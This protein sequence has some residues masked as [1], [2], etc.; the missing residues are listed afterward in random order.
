MMFSCIGVRTPLAIVTA[1]QFFRHAACMQ[2]KVAA[3]APGILPLQNN[4]PRWPDTVKVFSP[5]DEIAYV[6]KEVNHVWAQNGG[7]HEH[8]QFSNH[9]FALLFKPGVYDVSVPVGYYTQVMGLG[10]N[11]S[12]VKFI[13]SKGVYSESASNDTRPGSLD[14]FWRSAENFET[15]ADHAWWDQS[16]GGMM[17]ATSQATPLRRIIVK[18]SL[19][20]FQYLPGNIL[21][22]YASGGFIANS[23]VNGQIQ[24][25]SQQQYFARNCEAGGTGDTQGWEGGVW[26][27]VFVGSKG[28]PSSNCGR[29]ET[30]P[31][32]VNV[33]L[34][35][36]AA[37]KPYIVME[38]DGKFSLVIPPVSTD[39][40]G[41]DHTALGARLVSFEQVYV[42][43]SARDTA[44]SINTMLR[45]GL[46]VVLSP[47]I[48]HLH[49]PL[50]L[51]HDNQV[52]LGLGLATLVAAN[53]YAAVKVG[54]V[55]GV[56]LA[57]VLLEAGDEAPDVLLEWGDA[58]HQGLAENP[59]VMHDIFTRVC[60]PDKPANPRVKAM[61]RINSGHVIGD[62]LWLWRADHTTHGF[63]KSGHCACDH[64]LQVNGDDV[65]M[66]GLAAEHA[67]KD[68]VQWKGERGRV[69]FFQAE[70]PYD[71]S[72]DYGEKG[73][74]GYRVDDSVRVHEAWG[75][76]IYHDFHDYSVV[77]KSGII[78]PRHLETSFVSPLSVFLGGKGKMHHVINDLGE[79]TSEAMSEGEA[80]PTWWCP[81]RHSSASFLKRR[82][83]R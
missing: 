57:G 12:D 16:P 26:N 75:I 59:G 11:P 70:L 2:A 39:R 5:D 4:P 47:G 83:L 17:W 45:A 77:V 41:I 56:R 27:N 6:Q 55:D 68:I 78:A 30:D 48:Y 13:S 53:R 69:Y 61:V 51:K 18:N 8:G 64:A 73:Y 52:L 21:A 67:L 49:E 14:T 46:H 60:G 9:R 40:S 3:A 1:I 58:G 76:G 32:T 20:L 42:A 36:I 74:A 38:A 43:D 35:P 66:Y 54:N 19:I 80:K 15:H 29:T 63:V 34:A 79:E 24:S 28:F 25:G 33:A 82:Q 72:Q 22:N 31:P 50:E 81:Q 23:L 44:A 37:E 62:N 7:N 65:T 71:V 10:K